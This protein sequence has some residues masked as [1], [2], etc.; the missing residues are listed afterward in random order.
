MRLIL[1]VVLVFLFTGAQTIGAADNPPDVETGV[2][3]FKPVGDQQEIPEDYR[4]SGHEFTYT[5]KKDKDYP[6]S[7]YSVYQVTFPSPIQSPYPENNTVYAAYYRPRTDKPFPCVIVLDIT[8][9]D[10]SLSRLFSSQLAQN[11]IGALFVQ[12][13]YYGPRRP[14][15]SKM[16]LLSID[17]NNTLAAVQQTVLDIRRAAAWMESRPEIDGER[18]GIMG[19]SLGGFMAAL[20]AE[21]EPKLHRVGILLAGGGFVEA[22]YEDPRA[23]PLR[24]AW[25]FMGGNKG[26]VQRIIAP[27][28]PLT[29]AAN[30]KSRKVLMLCARKDEIVPATM[31]EALWKASGEQ[32]IVWFNSGHYT[33]AIYIVPA[34]THLVEHFKKE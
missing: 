3:K 7:G 34:I 5:L 17:M 24:I 19:T 2:V 29:C 27:V 12:M 31:A 18:L 1:G 9:G 10:Q 22:Y 14:K 28:D 8:G 20:S 21:M 30:L 23:A 33:A 26:M 25:E 16:R 32:K 4:L 13:A 11:G 15:G 6:L